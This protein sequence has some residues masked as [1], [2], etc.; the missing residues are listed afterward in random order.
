MKNKV[1]LVTGVT[2]QDGS[3]LANLLVKKGYKV[4]GTLRRGST[5]RFG[6]LEFLNLLDKVELISLEITEYSH[7]FN[8]L[9]EIQ[10]NK[11]FNLAAQS[12][13]GASFEQPI[14]TGE[15][16]GLGLT[17]VLDTLRM[18]SPDTRFYQASS[19]E[20]FGGSEKPLNE[21]SPFLPRSPYAAAKLYAHWVTVNYREAYD[22]FACSGILFNHES[23]R[24]GETFVTR[25]IT[26]AIAAIMAGTQKKLYLGNLDASRDWGFA[27][28]YVEAM[29]L[30]LQQDEPGDYV[31]G[32]GEGHTV[33]DFLDTAFGY[34]DMDW[35]DYVEIDPRYVRPNEVNSLLADATKARE[36]LGWKPK[37]D[38]EMLVK[39]MV[40]SDMEQAR[41]KPNGEGLRAL[42]KA[43]TWH[44]APL[45]SGSRL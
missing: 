7:V 5:P 4:F 38:F 19:S 23:P 17:R 1:A 2:G 31:I 40:D 18:V 10:P 9:R 44:G 14:A 43:Q 3:Y 16:T 42:A 6:R 21:K 8:I 37:V 11:I 33:R 27:P 28:D 20:M 13:V 35:R 26:R 12:F 45:S 29:W 24:R 15:I 32:T 30:M 22:L 34:V 25:K 36:T 41:L 39:L